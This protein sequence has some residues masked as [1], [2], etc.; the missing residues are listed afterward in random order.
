MMEDV[1]NTTDSSNLPEGWAAV[2]IR[3]VFDVN[4]PKPPRDALPTDG[5]VSFVPMPAVDADAGAITAAE[6]RPYGKV[7]KGY[8]AFRDGDV[9][10]AKITPCME[11]GKAA[12]A[13]GLVNGLGFGSTEFHV[14]RSRGAVLPDYVYRF[15]RQESYRRDAEMSMTGSVGQKR[16][17]AEFVAQTEIPLPPLAEQERIVAAIERLTAHIDAARDRLAR[18]SQILKRF[19]Q[20]VLD[21]ACSGRLTNQWR[22]SA[23]PGD[24]VEA[25]N[26][27]RAKATELEVPKRKRAREFFAGWEPDSV[28][29]MFDLPDGWGWIRAGSAYRQAGYGTSMK[30]VRDCSE[31]TP[32]LG[33]PHIASGRLEPAGAKRSPIN[34]SE[35]DR[36]RVQ[37]GDVIVCRT[38]GSLALIGKAAVVPELPVPYVFASYLIRV[39]TI[40]EALLPHYFH[41]ALTG[42]IGR[43]QIEELARSTAGQFNLS[44]GILGGLLI[45]LPPPPEQA[46]IVCRVESLMK[47][48]DTIERRVA[49]AAGRSDKLTQ[50][51]LAKAFRGELVPTEAELARAEGRSYESAAAMLE[52]VRLQKRDAG[53]STVRRPRRAGRP[54]T[55][56]APVLDPA[57][58]HTE[59][60]RAA[61]AVAL[62]LV[63]TQ[64]GRPSDEYL[65]ALI[66]AFHPQHCVN[67][68]PVAR[69]AAFKRLARNWPVA[70]S[71]ADGELIGWRNVRD[72]LE[73]TG[74]IA[75][76]DRMGSQSLSLQAEAAARL[77][78]TLPSGFDALCPFLLDAAQ[79]LR[80]ELAAARVRASRKS[81]VLSIRDAL[82]KEASAA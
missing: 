57:Y 72:Y 53:A 65:E 14:L 30:S 56:A 28:D 58:P 62:T 68:L 38:N 81:A 24:A 78:K 82:A 15:L 54:A 80:T 71:L 10:F 32:V 70:L 13:H 7:R 41:A 4:P 77:Q 60:E 35:L 64:S 37:P 25:L 43:M 49:A 34:G 1:P 44:L 9:I 46:E 3:D 52:R 74:A 8:T 61:C 79:T 26:A 11:N 33:V 18:V 5:E 76:S 75:I 40:G 63:R 17:P 22:E 69:Q 21:A 16:V 23:L 19:R 59:R 20:A 67:L 48:A 31:G 55:A 36:L 39:R 51:V 2:A 50:A 27:A 12:I 42:P 29:G 73:R 47:I 45:P 6:R 66:L